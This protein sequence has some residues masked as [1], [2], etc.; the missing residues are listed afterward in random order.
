M[1]SENPSEAVKM[2]HEVI[3]GEIKQFE[4]IRIRGEILRSK[5]KWSEEGENCSNLFLGLEKQNYVKKQMRKIAVDKEEISKFKMI[6]YHQ[7]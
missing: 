7:K 2:R 5:V 6:E 3:I 1:L 4:N